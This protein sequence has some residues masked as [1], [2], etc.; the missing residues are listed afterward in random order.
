MASPNFAATLCIPK[1]HRS[2]NLTISLA[3]TPRADLSRQQEGRNRSVHPSLDRTFVPQTRARLRQAT[4][5]RTDTFWTRFRHS[6]EHTV[7]T[8]YMTDKDKRRVASVLRGRAE[9]IAEIERRTLRRPLAALADSESLSSKIRRSM[10][11]MATLRFRIPFQSPAPIR[12]QRVSPRVLP[13]ITLKAK[14]PICSLHRRMIAEESHTLDPNGDCPNGFETSLPKEHCAPLKSLQ[15]STIVRIA[16]PGRKTP[17]RRHAIAAF[18]MGG[19][20]PRD[21]DV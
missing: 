2:P 1:A 16:K 12:S 3:D 20:H 15:T 8:A 5:T 9:E 7:A 17:A 13:K 18:D 11:G 19:L 14:R 6:P 4:R 10:N 21:H